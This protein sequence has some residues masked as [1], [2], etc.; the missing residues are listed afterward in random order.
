MLYLDSVAI[1]R[2]TKLN[3]QPVTQLSALMNYQ[4]SLLSHKTPTS[5]SLLTMSSSSSSA[6]KAPLGEPILEAEYLEP[7]D[8]RRDLE[9]HAGANG[10]AITVA[11]S[12]SS[13]IIFRCSRGGRYDPKGKSSSQHPSR[14]QRNTGTSKTD[15]PYRVVARKIKDAEG[16]RLEVIE[17]GHNHGPVEDLSEL[18]RYRIPAMTPQEH[19]TVRYL[20]EIGQDC[21]LHQ[22]L[23]LS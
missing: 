19:S 14:Q 5:S 20:F 9:V 3:I 17:N 10:F 15:C 11:S 18:P 4:A 21:F 16:W 23:Q 12:N 2:R 13:R 8:A 22:S 6:P 1:S 7:K